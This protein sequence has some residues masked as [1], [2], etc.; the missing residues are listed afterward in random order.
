M[1]E[2]LTPGRYE[3]DGYG[4]SV[5]FAGLNEAVYDNLELSLNGIEFFEVLRDEK[6]PF[7]SIPYTFTDL[8]QNKFYTVY[9]R[10]TYLDK[11]R[12][13]SCKIPVSASIKNNAPMLRSSGIHYN[14]GGGMASPPCQPI[15]EAY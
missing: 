15:A 10:A 6:E 7:Y 1:D 8:P 5:M 2:F 4:I 3:K 12:L 11:Q 14:I 9:G 13:I